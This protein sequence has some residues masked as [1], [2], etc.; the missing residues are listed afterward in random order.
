MEKP[1]GDWNSV[2]LY[3]FGQTAIHVVNGKVVMVNTDCSKFENNQY[4]PLTK[5]R[6]QL[7]SEG[8]EFYIRKIELESIKEIPSALLH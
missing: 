6:I 1:L 3:C 8:G 5:G 7:Q 4:I 2:D